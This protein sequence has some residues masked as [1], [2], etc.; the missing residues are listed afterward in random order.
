MNQDVLKFGAA[1]LIA[2]VVNIFLFFLMQYMISQH[3][4]RALNITEV[5][6]ID[7]I[8]SQ[9]DNLVNPQRERKPPPE[10]P[11]TPPPPE[12]QRVVTE[13]T[14]AVQPMRMPP[15]APSPAPSFGTPFLGDIGGPQWIDA[16]E[17]V[18][19]VRIPPE[20]PAH[21]RMRRIEG[22]VDVEFTVDAEGRVRNVRIVNA[23][24]PGVFDRA[25]INSV[26]Y[27]RF[28]PRRQDGRAIE[29]IARQRIEFDLS[30]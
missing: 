14:A 24:P 12:I 8:R 26:M 18:A 5:L 28:E 10:K 9:Q 6:R 3:S 4:V 23:E 27:W 20:Y 21:A 29:V 16:G 7:Y 30:G 19:L 1:M 22:F 25:A 17:L 13:T 15:I 11:E 2:I